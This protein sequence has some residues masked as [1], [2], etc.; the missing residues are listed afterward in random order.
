[1]IKIRKAEKEDC[2]DLFDWRND[3]TTV[4]MSHN[5]SSISWE[6]HKTWF[7]N[8]LN[9]INK[10]IYICE[11][12]MNFSKIGVVRFDMKH[13]FALIS[14]NLSPNMRGKGKSAPCIEASIKKFKQ[15]CPGVGS[16]H[17]E[18][19][20]ENLISAKLFSKCGFELH[21]IEKNMFYYIYKYT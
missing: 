1:M 16:I 9:N 3:E 10:R 12:D 15:S 7:N 13:N 14:I 8:T 18:V 2:K 17:A 20:K 6:E 21:K 4:R 19:K 5:I 11:D